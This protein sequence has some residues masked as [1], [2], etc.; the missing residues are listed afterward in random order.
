[1]ETDFSK[2]TDDELLNLLKKIK[3]EMSQCKSLLK[4]SQTREE[5]HEA[6]MKYNA[7]KNLVDQIKNYRNFNYS[8]EREFMTAFFDD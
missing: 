3:Q 2:M 8:V 7:A 4:L 6:Q 5:R 1:M